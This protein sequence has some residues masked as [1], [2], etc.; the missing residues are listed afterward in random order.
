ML[1]KSLKEISSLI[2]SQSLEQHQSQSPSQN[3]SRSNLSQVEH[4]QRKPVPD[5]GYC[6][7]NCPIC[8]GLG[9]VPKSSTDNNL[10]ICPNYLRAHWPKNI[11]IEEEEAHSLKLTNLVETDLVKKSA[12]YIATLF[13]TNA[14]M[15][16]IY[17]SV[18]T[19]KTVL[20]KAVLLWAMYEYGIYPAHYTTHAVMMDHLRSSFADKNKGDQYSDRVKYY[21][22]LPILAIDEI[23]RDKDS[24]FS[25]ASFG[26]I[27]D[28][29]YTLAKAGKAITIMASNFAPE[30]ILDI[31]LVDRL[32][33]LSNLV[34]NIKAPSLRRTGM[35]LE[36][37][38]NWWKDIEIK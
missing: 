8:N 29:R 9:L 10:I 26:K 13:T 7:P 36:T 24:E 6:V 20:L 38:T 27:M 11:G 12:D 4:E 23:G 21:S 19:G 1:M 14:G 30:E 31:Y 28:R 37:D 18:G 34:L 22:E 32:R 3:P 2:S 25:L 5:Y 33:D 35:Q 17:G 16:Y 15:I